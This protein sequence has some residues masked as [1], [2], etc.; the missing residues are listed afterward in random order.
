MK[1]TPESKKLT[2]AIRRIRKIQSQIANGEVKP[3]SCLDSL[4]RA[5]DNAYKLAQYVGPN[6][7]EPIIELARINSELVAKGERVYRER[8]EAKADYAAERAEIQRKRID[9]DSF[10]GELEL[11]RIWK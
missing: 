6:A 10:L 4:T 8:L 9:P 5:F 7:E 3:S 1:T 2:T 11:A